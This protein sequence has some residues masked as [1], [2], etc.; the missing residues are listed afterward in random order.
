[1][2]RWHHYAR[3]ILRIYVKGRTETPDLPTDQAILQ[4]YGW[5]SF[6]LDATGNASVAAWFASNEYKTSK[7]INLVEDCFED[8]VSLVSEIASF[9]ESEG[10]G[11]LYI[12]SRKMLR[13]AGIGAVHLSEIATNTGS[14]RYVRQDAYMVGPVAPEG[15]TVD[16]LSY[17]ITA[18]ASVLADYAQGL[19]T[20]TLFPGRG[21]DP[22]LDELL[23][24]PWVK[25]SEFAG[26]IDFFKRSLPLPEYDTYIVK[27]MPPSSAMYRPFWLKD[28]PQ[29]PDD[30]ATITHILCTD[31]RYHGKS[32]LTF[33]LPR[34][35]ELLLGFDG[36]IVEPQSLV[37][38][39][40][41]SLYGKGIIVMKKDTDLVHVSELGVEH[42]GLQ[43]KRIGK[44]AGM[45]F[46]IDDSGTWH[47][48]DHADNCECGDDHSEHI[49][50]LG[51]VEAGFSD[52]SFLKN[53]ARVYA[54]HGL[55]PR[56][57]SSAIPLLD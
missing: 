25:I 20:Q 33:T 53:D 14:P 21:D 55:D 38:H 46:R 13:Q 7:V 11:H 51:R 37:Y 28:F 1:M 45:H 19:S 29:D 48:V 56:S 57:D 31:G 12:I 24:M 44:F 27:H 4:H 8:P 3:Q 9:E 5:R 17:H 15:L 10:V 42:P 2:I 39:G 26:G 18:P 36:F 35:T 47:Q 6:F 41:G 30:P 43:I 40:M 32:D 49:R 16:C 52:G 34:L 50:L 22:I 23:S 54:E